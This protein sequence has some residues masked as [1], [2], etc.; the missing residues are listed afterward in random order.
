MCG[1]LY[2]NDK[3]NEIDLKKSY[4]ALNLQSHR[5]PDFQGEIGFINAQNKNDFVNVKSNKNLS[6]N[7]Y[8]GHNRLKIIDLNEKSNQP[9]IKNKSFFLYNGEFYNFQKFD[10][11]NTQSDTLTLFN[12]LEKNG[13]DFLNQ[14]NGM[15]SFVYGDLNKNKIFLSRDRYGKKPLYYFKNSHLFIASS[16]IKSIFKYLNVKTREINPE[17]LARFFATKL[18]DYSSE[19]TFYKEIKSVKAGEVLELDQSNFKIK[20]ILNVKKFPL[21][22]F[23]LISRDQIKENLK[24]DLQN[25]VAARLI[26]DAPVGVLVSGG[27]D[28]TAIVSNIINLKKENYVNFFYAKQFVIKKF[29]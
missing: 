28:S 26:S 14:V 19:K 25:A 21:I 22:N 4:E 11:E 5:G 6:V 27:L 12:E 8:F 24:I 1:F 20:K 7:Q 9:I 23:K 3:L 17:Y 15:W 2:I 10:F 29:P 18:N 13:L 16:E